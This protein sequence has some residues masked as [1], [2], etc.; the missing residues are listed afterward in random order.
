MHKNVRKRLFEFTILTHSHTFIFATGTLTL[1]FTHWLISNCRWF[2]KV[3][4]LICLLVASL[5]KANQV[6]YK[7]TAF[8][9]LNCGSVEFANVVNLSS[10]VSKAV[11]GKLLS[12]ETQS[13]L[14][15][16]FEVTIVFCILHN[17]RHLQHRNACHFT[18]LL[19]V[20]SEIPRFWAQ[21]F[22][23]IFY[24]L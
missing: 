12:Q 16:A 21:V 17:P 22:S 5:L 2:A 10:F 14:H 8:P 4:L 6:Q 23:K 18:V 13:N 20:C 15:K 11:A 9:L 24:A 7:M 1:S 3:N 19:V